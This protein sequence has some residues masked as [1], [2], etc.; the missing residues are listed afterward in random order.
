M[1]RIDYFFS[2]LSPFAYLAGLELERLADRQGA[3]IAYRPVDLMEVFT[4]TGGVPL[5]KRHHSRLEYREQELARASRRKGLKL[6]IHPAHFPVDVTVPSCTVIA[7]AE[8][9]GEDETDAGA[10][11]HALLKAVWAEDKDISK[12]DVVRQVTSDLGLDPGLVAEA[13]DHADTYRANTAEAIE[14]GVFGSPFYITD[15]GE[16]F[17]GHDRLADLEAHLA[18]R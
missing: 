15:D 6:N 12:P 4:A 14:R 7:A 1:A 8:K 5:A 11:A 16:K 18:A 10:L 13:G 3:E 17:W 2:L 9:T